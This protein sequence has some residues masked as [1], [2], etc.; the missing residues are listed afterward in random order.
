MKKQVLILM[1]IVLGSFSLAQAQ[2]AEVDE[3]YSRYSSGEGVFAMS[4]NHKILD[5][6]DLDFDWEDQM[7]NVTGDIH[8]AKFIAFG[9]ESHPLKKLQRL[10]T[11]IAGTGLELIE[12]PAEADLEKLEFFQIYGQKKGS[13]YENI[14][15]LV[16]TE[17]AKHGAFVAI[18][19]KLKITQAS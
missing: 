14:Y 7:K 2:S 12:V 6:I 18:N 11:E 13:Y 19:G 5:A 16:V 1:G 10:S 15:L 3:I 17:D 9:E 4:I 8:K